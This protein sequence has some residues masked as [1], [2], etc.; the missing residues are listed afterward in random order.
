MF[1]GEA[2]SVIL[3][4][5]RAS[6]ASSNLI[7]ARLV[8]VRFGA[9]DTNLYE[10]VSANGDT[11]PPT[12]PGAHLDLHLPNG[13]IRQYSLLE[14]GSAPVSYTIG[15]KRDVKSR[16]GSS[17]LHEQIRVGSTLHIGGP[18][19]N[20]PLAK[21]AAHTILIAGGIGITPIWCMWRELKSRGAPARL[22]YA[23]RSR[24]DALFLNEMIAD[25]QVFLRFDDEN[26]GSPLDISN[27]MA[28][29]SEHS[30]V[31][32]CG[33]TPMLEAF[34]AATEHLHLPAERVHVEYFTPQAEAASE[35][36]FTVELARSR[37]EI[38]V[39]PGQTIL[40]ALTAAGIRA[41]Y[42]CE[43]GICGACMTTV[44]GGVPDHRD[45]VL[46]ESER[47]SS[48]TMMI[49][50]SGSMTDRLVLDL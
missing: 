17:F 46:T 4:M 18:R 1:R 41:P 15:V 21:D 45:S 24:A 20:F 10:F 16:G 3:A 30:H 13:L 22:V 8:A 9:R 26:S 7:E 28:D 37:K 29:A 36:G 14:S 12:E 42:S 31:F 27:V 38:Q 43:E 49:C 48:K 35:G 33:P 19:N 25:P 34:K 32:C 2:E 47:K 39:L 40:A 5:G 23:C 11:L 50:C 6:S 44:L